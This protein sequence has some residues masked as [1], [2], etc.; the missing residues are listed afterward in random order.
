MSYTH[1]VKIKF[2]KRGISLWMIWRH[3]QTLHIYGNV[4]SAFYCTYYIVVVQ[5]V[6]KQSPS[7]CK[8]KS[9]YF[10]TKQYLLKCIDTNIRPNTPP[11][12]RDYPS[13]PA[14]HLHPP[15]FT[16]SP[17]HPPNYMHIF[18]YLTAQIS[19]HL[20]G[21]YME[22]GFHLDFTSR[23]HGKSQPSYPGWLA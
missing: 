14:A 3:F 12:T 10:F 8:T 16:F 18:D 21:V 15:N 6:R 22:E 11:F 23:L 4:E 5:I 20:G 2:T 17:R 19:V 1:I 9:V 13:L 7:I